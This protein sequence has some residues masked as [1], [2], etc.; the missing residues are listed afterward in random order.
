VPD[1]ESGGG[2]FESCRGYLFTAKWLMFNSWIAPT[3]CLSCG[4]IESWRV[5]QG[6]GCRNGVSSRSLTC[7]SCPQYPDSWSAEAVSA[8]LRVV[9][10]WAAGERLTVADVPS[11]RHYLCPA[12]AQVGEREIGPCPFPGHS[13]GEIF[14]RI[15]PE[16]FATILVTAADLLTAR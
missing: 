5:A 6:A 16:Q 10:V 15:P 12:G 11:L 3:T 9:D 8:D 4:N 13:P 14:A 7:V 2:R 1:Y